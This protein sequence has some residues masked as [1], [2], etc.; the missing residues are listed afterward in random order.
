MKRLY[1]HSFKTSLGAFHSAATSKGIVLI[2]LPGEKK[3]DFIRRAN[4][5]FPDY[6]PVSGGNLNRRLE[7]QIRE[8]LD[9]HR[10][11]FT[12]PVVMTGTPFQQK[13]LRK[14]ARIPYGRTRTY[15]EIA[16]AVGSPGASRAVGSAN[17]R[18][19]LPIVIPCHRVVAAHGLG[20]YGGGLNMK[21][22][23]LQLEGAY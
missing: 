4:E 13:V 9:G 19:N 17:A 20:G 14:V 15:G 21:T 5:L 22:T 23:L 1:L 2:A 6:A 12:V 18:N 11:K 3:R 7:K 8:Y 16:R 10:R